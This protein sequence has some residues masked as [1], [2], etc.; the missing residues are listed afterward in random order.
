M[1]TSAP[2]LVH[3][4]RDAQEPTY[5]AELVELARV[6]VVG[7]ALLG[8]LLGG[9]LLRLSMLMLRLTSP[10]TVVGMTS[11]D[12]FT[13]GEVTFG[14]TYNLVVLGGIVGLVGA[15]AYVLVSPW[16][17]GPRWFHAVTVGMTA[18][19]LVGAM[20]IHDD[21]IDFHVLQP[22]WLA[23]S[24]F[25]AV[26]ALFGFALVYSVDAV[27]APTSWTARG[28]AQWV[29][30]L[31]TLAVA[32]QIALIGTMVLAP[33]ALL[34]PVRRALLPRVQASAAAM[35]AIR[36]AFLVIPVVSLVAV[37]QDISAVL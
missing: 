26:P 1:S 12:G 13:I 8:L 14:G 37:V 10:D 25:V 22:T 15:A 3:G 30:P 34:L 29:L 4:R 9:A 33:V 23:L 35:L 27:A 5:V 36:A 16:L 21:G 11:D 31:V 32:P 7:G 28:R 20:V 19:M 17:I 24:T 18:G 2:T 6:L